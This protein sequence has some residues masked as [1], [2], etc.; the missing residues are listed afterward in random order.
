MF[1][2]RFRL[3]VFL[4]VL[5]LWVASAHAATVALVR[6][7]SSSRDLT[8]TVSRLHGELLA[9]GLEVKMV[10]R[11]AERGQDRTVSRAWI[12]KVTAEGGID[13]VIDIVGDAAPVAVDVWVIGTPSRRF[14]VSRVLVEANSSNAAERLAIRAIE[15]LRSSFLEI[16]MASRER[17]SEPVAEPR[18][19]A[20]PQGE[21]D[22][23]ASPLEILG[24]EAGAAMLTSL[25]GVGPAIS[26]ILR[27]G[28]TARSRFVV[29]AALVGFGSRPT[30][31]NSAGTARVATQYAVVGGRYR[32]SL[33]HSLR[34][35]VAV[36]AG[37]LRTAVEGQ[38]DWPR[39]GHSMD[40]GSFLLEGSL[41]AELQLPDRYYLTLAAHVHVAEPSVAIHIADTVAATIGRPNLALTLT[42]GAWL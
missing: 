39:Q 24:F 37:A 42:V 38:A 6:P 11:S 34:P 2:V 40:Q 27:F 26:P 15:L 20:L 4:P 33:N 28:W 10:N 13:A 31:E 22:T 8:E 18:A 19:T 32:L 12:Q 35:F 7:P 16:D 23:P 29:Q 9:V 41:G 5:L 17:R 21:P 3:V 1:V 36:S 30:I 25:D 14:Q